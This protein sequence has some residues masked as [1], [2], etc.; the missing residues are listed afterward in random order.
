M[1]QSELNASD[2]FVIGWLPGSEGGTVAD[3]MMKGPRAMLSMNLK[4]HC[5]CPG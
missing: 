1:G 2:A 4:A 3:V 5:R